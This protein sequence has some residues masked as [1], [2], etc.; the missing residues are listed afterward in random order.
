MDERVS[1][2]TGGGGGIGL[3]TARLLRERGPVVVADRDPEA[4][5]AASDAGF[6]P[7]QLDVRETAGWTRLADEVRDR[8]GKLDHLVHNAGI[9][10][11]A[12]LTETSDDAFDRTYETNVRS[13]LVGTREL[14]RLLVAATGSIV[15]V[16]SVAG[17][18]GQDSS[19]AYVA[20]KGAVIA[21]TRALAIEL[22]PH[23]VRVNCVSPGTT[24][25]PL[26][27]R[28]FERLTDGAE[29]KAQLTRRHPLGRLLTPEEV[30]PT[31]VHLLSPETAGGM[32]GANLVVDGGLTASFD[33]G[34]S[35]AGGG[36]R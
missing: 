21:L 3:A 25:T 32:T 29:A 22:A 12:P 27:E 23:G 6:I 9:A 36:P 26:L 24:M 13:I 19:A 34:N 28:H 17:L 1:V 18:V 16:A 4:L 10:P 35:F 30:A 20:S 7:F 31:I 5:R 2:V 8:F 33:Y 15:N 14:W 11:I